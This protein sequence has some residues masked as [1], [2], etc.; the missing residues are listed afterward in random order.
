M[1]SVSFT[2]IGLKPAQ[3]KAVAKRA[4][5]VGKSP[6]EY[7]RSLV[8]RDLLIGRS[9]DEILRPIREGFAKSGVTEDELD[10]LVTRARRDFHARS[11]RKA[12]A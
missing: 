8:E 11:R 3:V 9:F 4:K 6:S 7:L 12:R 10:V 1:S 2:D 5:Q